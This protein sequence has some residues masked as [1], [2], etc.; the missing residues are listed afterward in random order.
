LTV[1]RRQDNALQVAIDVSDKLERPLCTKAKD[2]K[3][4][5]RFREILHS[6]LD[7][8]PSMRAAMILHSNQQMEELCGLA[9]W[10]FQ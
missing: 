8:K 7:T 2:R 6:R 4:D 1:A 5:C 10:K 3:L 9:D